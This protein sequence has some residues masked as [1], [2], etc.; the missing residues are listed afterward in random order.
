MDQLHP[1]TTPQQEH[2]IHIAIPKV[3][4]GMATI[5]T[6]TQAIAMAITMTTM[7]WQGSKTLQ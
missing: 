5:P 3:T 7:H 6:M 1:V 4:L 2:N